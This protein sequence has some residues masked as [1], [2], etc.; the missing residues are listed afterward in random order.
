M[1]SFFLYRFSSMLTASMLLSSAPLLGHLAGFPLVLVFQAIGFSYLTR[2]ATQLL[3]GWFLSRHPKQLHPLILEIL[4]GF[5]VV[6]YML[7]LWKASFMWYLA[8]M[9]LSQIG[10]ALLNIH[11]ESFFQKEEGDMLRNQ[12]TLKRFDYGSQLAMLSLGVGLG[13]F[14][15]NGLMILFALGL[16]CTL[17]VIVIALKNYEALS[18]KEVGAPTL[19]AESWSWVKQ[20]PSVILKSIAFLFA[21]VFPCYWLVKLPSY[22]EE[23]FTGTAAVSLA[24]LAQIG[25]A[26]TGTLGNYLLLTCKACQQMSMVVVFLVLLVLVTG[27]MPHLTGIYALS[28]LYLCFVLYFA[29]TTLVKSNRQLSLSSENAKTITGALLALDSLSYGLAAFFKNHNIPL[30]VAALLGLCLW[31]LALGLQKR[32]TTPALALK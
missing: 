29:S 32:A 7:T 8:G 2:A 23:E 11:A 17:G 6:C 30:V 25:V 1:S 24:L 3:G 16:T 26:L 13:Y 22:I 14:F 21:S 10:A 27:V 18:W 9:L 15:A 19:R 20:N 28:V 31:G 12:T 5:A 4:K